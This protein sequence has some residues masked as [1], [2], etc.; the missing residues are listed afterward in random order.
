MN[1]RSI[2]ERKGADVATIDI[3]ASLAD[4]AARLRDHRVGALVVSPD[5]TAIVRIVSER[6]V[7]RA[8]ASHGASA[9]GRTVESVMSFD[10][11]TCTPADGVP[12][13]MELMTDHRIR[14]L[15]VVDDVGRLCGIVSIGDV[16]K[17]R[18][19]ELEG[20]NRALA[21]YLHQGR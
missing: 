21:D 20:E 2:L 11:T 1:V 18:L 13:L 17:A 8:V 15:P 5:H 6:D 3:D 4:A 10:V 19:E 9:L 16:V 7:V 12:R 14:H